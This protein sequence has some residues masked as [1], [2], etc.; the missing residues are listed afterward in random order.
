[1]HTERREGVASIK[2]RR[3]DL[4]SDGVKDFMT[5]SKRSRLKEDLESSTWRRC[6]ATRA[7]GTPLSSPKETMWYLFDPTPSGCCKTDAH[8]MDFGSISTWED[9]TTRFLAQFFPPGRTAKLLPHHGIDLWLQ[10][11]IFYDYVDYTTQM[12]VDY[13][14]GGRLRK[15]RLEVAWET[16][17]DLAQYE[18]EGWNDPIFP[19]EGSL[20]YKNA[21]IEQLLGVME[22]KVD[23]L[24]KDA[25][26]LMV[27]SGNLSGPTSN[28]MHQLP[29]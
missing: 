3:R 2:Q 13:A 1:M 20:N 26:S 29:L 15:L 9:L 19:E 16:I 22:C 18:E 5:V 4:Q 28:K 10:V 8:S 23:T 6:L 17:K 14:V 24:M 25:I 11:K 21:N 12:V 27:K 7:I